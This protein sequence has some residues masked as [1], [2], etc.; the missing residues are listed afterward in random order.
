MTTLVDPTPPPEPG[1]GNRLRARDL[2]NTPLI[3]KPV[4]EGNEPGKDNKPW[5]YIECEVW[6]LDRQ[7]VVAHETGIRFSWWRAVEQLKS[8]IG[9]YVACR[10]VEQDDN[11]IILT[12]LSG[13]AREVAEAAL[14]TLAAPQVDGQDVSEFSEEPF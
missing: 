2:K 12:P 5:V 13:A 9:Q 6:T 3:L 14:A 4:R 7:G 11:S 1:E 8:Q 10:P